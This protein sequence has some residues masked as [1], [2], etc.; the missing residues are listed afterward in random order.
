V[1]LHLSLRENQL[2]G[3]RGESKDGAMSFGLPKDKRVRG[4][5]S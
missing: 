5:S 4:G 1:F 2:L 3:F